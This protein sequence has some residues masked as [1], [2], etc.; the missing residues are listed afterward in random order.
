MSRDVRRPPP[1]RDLDSPDEIA[2]MVRRFYRDIAQDDQLGPM[3]NDVARVDWGEHLAKLTQFWCRTVL[4]IEGYTGNPYRAHE[5]V[6]E[7]SAFTVRHFER[8]LE[9]FHDTIELGWVG[10]N[11]PRALVLDQNVARVHGHQ[12]AGASLGEL[13]PGRRPERQLRV[14]RDGLLQAPDD[15]GSTVR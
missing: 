9:L 2:E 6:H 1:D 11:A 3:F 14:R 13:A 15:R 4:G 10:P 8:W 12:L 5:L 7:R